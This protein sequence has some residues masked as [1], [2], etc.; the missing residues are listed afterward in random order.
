MRIL[1]V[2]LL[3]GLASLVSVF[4][5]FFIITSYRTVDIYRIPMDLLIEE[6]VG[7][8]LNNDSIHFGSVYKGGTSE[9]EI[10]IINRY[11]IPLKATILLYGNISS[12]VTVT[13]NNMVIPSGSVKQVQFKASMP[14]N[15]SFGNYTGIAEIVLKKV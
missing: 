8:N 11:S 12:Y 10:G 9:R 2:I 7:I 14:S 15:C 4:I 1:N 3:I 6:K 5:S 13:D